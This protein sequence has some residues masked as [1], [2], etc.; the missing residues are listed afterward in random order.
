M[1]ILLNDETCDSEWC[2]FE[3]QVAQENEIP[4]KCIVD[5]ETS[6]KHEVINKLIS[7]DEVPHTHT[8]SQIKCWTTS[9]V[10]AQE[11]G[12]S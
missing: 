6:S 4:V 7:H 10:T 12:R 2:R 3:W 5:V 11:S 8:Y 9:T 1:I